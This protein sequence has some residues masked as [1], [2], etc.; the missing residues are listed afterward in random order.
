LSFNLFSTID[1]PTK[2]K[3]TVSLID[4][5]FIDYSQFGKHL[6]SPINNGLSDHDAQLLII[7]NICLQTHK[8]KIPTISTKQIFNDQS[9][10][11]FQMQ[12]S[13]ETWDNIFSGN[14]IDTIFN[15]FLNTYL[16][17]FLF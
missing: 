2:V 5:I 10:L 15:S 17:F 4:S 6:V 13:Y 11:N 9:L 1:F 7:K 12:L 14:D 3:I 8:H 16:R